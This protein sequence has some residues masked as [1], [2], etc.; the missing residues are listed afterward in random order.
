MPYILLLC[1]LDFLTIFMKKSWATIILALYGWWDCPLIYLLQIKFIYLITCISPFFYHNYENCPHIHTQ[2]MA[3]W[4]TLAEWMEWTVS[5]RLRKGDYNTLEPTGSVSQTMKCLEF[6]PPYTVMSLL[7]SSVMDS[8]RKHEPSG[9]ETK[10]CLLFT[11]VTVARVLVMPSRS[12]E[13]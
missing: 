11:A 13:P 2:I 1:I 9:L 7:E 3:G 4:E 5:L 12:P 8:G 10:H 6:Y